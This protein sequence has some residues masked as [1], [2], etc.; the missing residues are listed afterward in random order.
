MQT[1]HGYNEISDW[2][3]PII[4]TSTD[5]RPVS[6]RMKLGI[7]IGSVTAKAVVLDGADNIIESRYTRTRGQPVE[8]FLTILEDILANIRLTSSG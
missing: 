2:L 7:D 1:Q 6:C 4:I 3:I 8:T 5:F